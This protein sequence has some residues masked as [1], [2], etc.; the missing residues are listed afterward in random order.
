MWELKTYVK[1]DV[2]QEHRK[3]HAV[4]HTSVAHIRSEEALSKKSVRACIPDVPWP[5]CREW[6]KNSARKSMIRAIAVTEAFVPCL[7]GKAF[8]KDLVTVEAHVRRHTITHIH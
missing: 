1:Y 5:H 3:S 7:L 8:W 2:A 6:S 4:A